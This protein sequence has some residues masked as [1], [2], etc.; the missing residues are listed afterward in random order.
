MLFKFDKV[1][2]VMT[3]FLGTRTF[4]TLLT[5][6]YIL[7]FQLMSWNGCQFNV[8]VKICIYNFLE[9]WKNEGSKQSLICYDLSFLLFSEFW[10][11]QSTPS[12]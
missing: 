11:K 12:G 7:Y 5:F 8:E 4:R 3:T 10:N 9:T 2:L 1:T 6:I